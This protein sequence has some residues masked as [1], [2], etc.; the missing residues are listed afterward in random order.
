MISLI[1]FLAISILAFIT[2]IV[3]LLYCATKA[4]KNKITLEDPVWEKRFDVY[5]D[6]E[7]EAR[8]HVTT[9]FMERFLNLKTT[10]GC[11][12]AKCAFFD[13]K[14]MIAISTKKNLF[15]IGNLFKSCT[16]LKNKKDFFNEIVSIIDLVDYLK[17]GENTKL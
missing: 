11:R 13:D 2:S 16:N 1:L 5:S 3:F 8:Y 9:G 10:F 17:L 14:V 4:P 6:D 15:E 7:I 12:K